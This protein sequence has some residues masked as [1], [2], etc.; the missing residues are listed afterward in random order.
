MEPLEAGAASGVGLP[1]SDVSA[2]ACGVG[3]SESV[4]LPESDDES[5]E[6]LSSVSGPDEPDDG[7]DSPAVEEAVFE[8]GFFVCAHTVG[9]SDS[10]EDPEPDSES[11]SE[12]EV[13]PELDDAEDVSDSESDSES[14]LAAEATAG[15]GGAGVLRRR[16]APSRGMSSLAVAAVRG[17][18]D[19][20]DGVPKQ[21]HTTW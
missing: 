11:W 14:E 5:D 10:E 15:S 16:R 21:R 6:E 8:P 19:S 3:A 2:K 13:S 12:L 7:S 4:S 9:P 20:N 1:S 18:A 17:R